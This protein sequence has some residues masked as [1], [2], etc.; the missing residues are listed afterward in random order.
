[1][2]ELVEGQD[3]S[4]VLERGPMPS[5]EALRIAIEVG[6]CFAARTRSTGRFEDG[7]FRGVVHGDIKPRNIR[8]RPTGASRSSTFGIAKALSLSRRL[9][10]N[11][12]GS[13]H[14]A[15][16]E[17]LESGHRGR[18]AP[19]SGRSASSSTRCWR[20]ASPSGPRTR[21]GSSA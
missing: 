13:L 15:S 6:E 11:E 17:R 19:T 20:A 18:A 14:Y 8:S 4:H 1:M 3:L 10:R 12:F 21:S 5:A 9:T 7:A 2:M 16:P